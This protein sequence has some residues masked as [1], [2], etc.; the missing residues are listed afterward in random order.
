MNTEALSFEEVSMIVVKASYPVLF[1][2]P[3]ITYFCIV[4]KSPTYL[5]ALKRDYKDIAKYLLVQRTD[6]P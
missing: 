1:V 4:Y 5:S 6:Y 2:L 3:R